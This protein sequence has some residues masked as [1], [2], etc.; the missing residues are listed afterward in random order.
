MNLIFLISIL[1]I[2]K[3]SFLIRKDKQT[4]KIKIVKYKNHPSG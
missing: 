3:V 1:Y 4:I 2:K